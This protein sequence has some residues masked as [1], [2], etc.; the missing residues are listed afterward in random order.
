MLN[1]HELKHSSIEKEAPAIVE[2]V[3]KW[4]H[5]LSGRHFQ[6]SVTFMYDAT[7]LSKIKNDKVSRWRTELSEFDF[8]IIYRSGRLNKAPDASSGL[9]NVQS[10][11]VHRGPPPLLGAPPFDLS[12]AEKI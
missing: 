9:R 7:N 2:A 11:Q 4:S 10:V 6:K 8:D 3:R 5:F 12:R 1:K